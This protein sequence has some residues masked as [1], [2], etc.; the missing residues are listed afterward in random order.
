MLFGFMYGHRTTATRWG[1]FCQQDV[2]HSLRKSGKG[3]RSCTQIYRLVDSLQ[4]WCWW[5]AGAPHTERVWN[6]RSI[7]RDGCNLN[8]EFSVKLGHHSGSCLSP[9]LFTIDHQGSCLSPLFFTVWKPSPKGFIQ[10]VSGKTVYRCPALHLWIF[11]GT[12][13]GADSLEVHYGKKGTTSK[14][15]QN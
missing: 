12:A 8:E 14:H 2:V 1:P 6:A 4:A 10:D 3:I 13:G 15:G 11:R 9:L 5:V 7:V